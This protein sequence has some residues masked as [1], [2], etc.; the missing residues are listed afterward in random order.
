MG[1]D[2]DGQTYISDI[3]E[4]APLNR[5]SLGRFYDL[6]YKFEFDSAIPETFTQ[7]EIKSVFYSKLEDKYII[8]DQ[9]V[10][11]D[12]LVIPEYVEMD[13]SNAKGRGLKYTVGEIVDGVREIIVSFET[14]EPV[15]G[16]ALLCTLADYSGDFS[17]TTTGGGILSEHR[18]VYRNVPAT[19]QL[20]KLT[21]D[22]NGNSLINSNIILNTIMNEYSDRDDMS[23]ISASFIINKLFIN[24]D[25]EEYKTYLDEWPIRA[26]IHLDTSQVYTK[27][28]RFPSGNN[29]NYELSEI[30]IKDKPLANEIA[31]VDSDGKIPHYEDD[32]F[33]DVHYMPI[34]VELWL[35]SGIKLLGTVSDY[36]SS[37]MS[38]GGNKF[39]VEF[40]D[41]SFK[42]W[43]KTGNFISEI[44]PVRL[45]PSAESTTSIPF[46]KRLLKHLYR[47][48]E[49]NSIMKNLGF[50]E[51]DIKL[52]DGYWNKSTGLCG[53]Q[54]AG[55]TY[56]L[57]NTSTWNSGSSDWGSL[58][59]LIEKLPTVF[60]IK[61]SNEHPDYGI[62]MPTAICGRNSWW[63]DCYLETDRYD[64]KVS[65]GKRAGWYPYTT[66]YDWDT[67]KTIVSAINK[68][69]NLYA[70]CTNCGNTGKYTWF[71]NRALLT[72]P[73]Y[74]KIE[75]QILL[76]GVLTSTDDSL[77]ISS[78]KDLFFAKESTNDNVY[79]HYISNISGKCIN[80]SFSYHG[81][82]GDLLNF[83]FAT[84]LENEKPHID[85]KYV[86]YYNNE[87]ERYRTARTHIGG[88]PYISHL[89]NLLKDGWEAV[90][91]PKTSD[92]HT[93]GMWCVKG[94]V[95]TSSDPF[96][97]WNESWLNIRAG[98]GFHK[99]RSSWNG[100]DAFWPGVVVAGYNFFGALETVT[101]KHG[102][103]TEISGGDISP[104]AL[105]P[106]TTGKPVYDVFCQIYKKSEDK[107]VD[108]K[109]NVVVDNSSKSIDYWLT[110]YIKELIQERKY[111]KDYSNAQD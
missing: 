86:E 43:E 78:N 100:W 52:F 94:R 15:D 61:F 96:Y 93:A 49:F 16:G 67:T 35:G 89:K 22:L 60:P 30:K 27:Y 88:N 85:S 37:F 83:E 46:K 105:S 109:E 23:T 91:H 110:L 106:D 72:E 63:A 1:K 69:R 3:V 17:I 74:K 33:A 42:L 102:S 82:T 70:I 92:L 5:I 80:C 31:I 53:H 19:V 56:E 39:S 47:P 103:K 12:V 6:G 107:F 48:I 14:T 99:I 104:W 32:E 62:N 97:F 76:L 111:E 73:E 51:D 7:I 66:Y 57:R 98:N 71:H 38:E 50:S 25:L 108:N 8:F 20:A 55:L 41:S 34:S 90:Q 87:L 79:R 59:N 64:S 54:N 9:T 2:F 65:M 75:K 4:D 45:T 77:I 44:S 21:V 10:D 24:K 18:I 40:K 101:K 13:F 36:T 84:D 68:G 11:K 29:I 95:S 58:E 26:K 81:Y 28:G